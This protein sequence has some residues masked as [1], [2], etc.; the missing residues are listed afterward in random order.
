MKERMNY[1]RNNQKNFPSSSF[2][3]SSQKIVI[4]TECSIVF[5]S[6]FM[7]SLRSFLSQ[8]TSDKYRI[9]DVCSVRRDSQ[10]ERELTFFL[11]FNIG[12]SS[13]LR[14][15]C[16]WIARTNNYS[17]NKQQ[18]NWIH[19][20]NVETKEKRRRRTERKKTEEK[21]SNFDET[22]MKMQIVLFFLFFCV[23]FCVL[24]ICVISLASTPSLR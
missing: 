6:S 20:Q 18:K 11:L 7:S 3:F 24:Y 10:R 5:S 12:F 1:T 23:D 8:F 4:H 9:R 2:S 16:C 17:Q 19:Q 21:K 14:I 15:D 22:K 13:A